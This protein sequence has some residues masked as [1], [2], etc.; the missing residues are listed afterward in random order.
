VITFVA[1]ESKPVPPNRALGKSRNDHGEMAGP[2]DH[3]VSSVGIALVRGTPVCVYVG[4]DG[5]AGGPT[6]LPELGKCVTMKDADTAGISLGVE[7][8]VVDTAG[9]G[10]PITF[11]CAKHEAAALM[12]PASPPTQFGHAV[13]PES[14]WECEEWIRH[15]VPPCNH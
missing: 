2:G 8:I 9:S 10:P 1:I 4:H 5:K 12:K 15:C 14:A 13:G 3:R 7:F 6:Y 11:D